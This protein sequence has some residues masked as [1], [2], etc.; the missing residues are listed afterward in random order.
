MTCKMDPLQQ[1]RPKRLAATKPKTYTTSHTLRKS[2]VTNSKSPPNS[3]VRQ[4]PAGT[5]MQSP[6]A[7][8]TPARLA[9]HDEADSF[10]VDVDNHDDNMAA[11]NE[12][13][14]ELTQAVAPDDPVLSPTAMM[15][16][17]M[18]KFF[19]ST[20]ERFERMIKTAVESFISKLTELERNIGAS[21]EFERERIDQ[22]QV[23]QSELEEKLEKMEKEMEEMKARVSQNAAAANKSERFLRRNN[24]RLVGMKEA[25]QGQRE[26]CVDIVEKVL[27]E[28]FELTCKVERAHRDGR[29]S[30]G[31]P[32]HILFKLLSYRQ[33]VD[34]MKRAREV[35]KDEPYFLIDD[36]TPSDLQEKQKYVRQVQELYKQGTKLRF[37]AGKWRQSGGV[38]YKFE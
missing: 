23:N 18:D 27:Q 35:L 16:L 17:R 31:K 30:E 12:P 13:E 33:K 25:P 1:K 15:S 10:I 34:V 22:L 11:M 26:E 5:S 6:V 2:P 3:N 29:R 9:R 14:P 38:P 20:T 7:R 4:R 24:V 37:F 21:L 8:P 32:R 19:K 28:K 36:L